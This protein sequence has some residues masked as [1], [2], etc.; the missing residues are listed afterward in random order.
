VETRKA[1]EAFEIA[2]RLEHAESRTRVTAERTVLAA[3]GGGCQA[4][5]GSHAYVDGATVVIIGVIV[6]PDGAQ[7]IRQRHHGPA[8]DPIGAGETLAQKLLEAGG[9]EILDAVYGAQA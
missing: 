7:F 1:G 5:I 9:K 8:S 6:S 3:L 4:P 2:R